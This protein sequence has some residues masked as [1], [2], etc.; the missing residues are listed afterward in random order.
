MIVSSHKKAK[1]KGVV[2]RRPFFWLGYHAMNALACENGEPLEPTYSVSELVKFG[3]Q[4]DEA[5][6]H[7]Q[8]V[9]S[10]PYVPQ[11]VWPSKRTDGIE[12]GHF[13]ITQVPFDV[14][15]DE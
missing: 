11:E 3:M 4:H 13:N 15:I 2:S 1:G 14:E 9:P 12:G 6:E 10:F 5:L 7:L 8:A